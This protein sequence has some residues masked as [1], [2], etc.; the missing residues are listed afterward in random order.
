MGTPSNFP[1]DP[2]VNPTWVNIKAAAVPGHVGNTYAAI[3]DTLKFDS[4]VVIKPLEIPAQIGALWS[5]VVDDFMEVAWPA[6]V[7]ILVGTGAP[8]FIGLADTPGPSGTGPPDYKDFELFLLRVNAAGT[9]LEY[10]VTIP[11]TQVLDGT[12]DGDGTKRFF[13]ASD[14][15]DLIETREPAET[16]VLTWTAPGMTAISA[17][18]VRF[19]VPLTAVRIDRTGL[20]VTNRTDMSLASQTD[21][22][23]G[24][25]GTRAASFYTLDDTGAIKEYTSPPSAATLDAE[26]FLG[27]ALHDGSVI[28]S[29]FP[30][31]IVTGDLG[32]LIRDEIATTGNVKV[33][34]G[35][36]VD[37]KSTL[38]SILRSTDL[39]GPGL[40][41]V[42]DI[43]N[44]NILNIPEEDPVVFDVVFADGTVHLSDVSTLPKLFESTPGVASTYTGGKRTSISRYIL[45]PDG[46][47]YV[48]LGN[49]E[50]NNFSAAVDALTKDL[51]DN[52]LPPVARAIGV[53]LAVVI[54][55]RDQTDWTLDR[56]EI[57]VLGG[58]QVGGGGSSA[59]PALGDLTD[60]VI[61]A[62][63]EGEGIFYDGVADYVNKSIPNQ[64]V[65]QFEG[66]VAPATNVALP[67][68]IV[69]SK[70]VPSRVHLEVKTAPSTVALEVDVLSSGTTIFPGAVAKI[71]TSAFTGT[72][73][74][75][76]TALLANTPWTLNIDAGDATWQDL[77]VTIEGHIVP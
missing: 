35:G 54:I 51:L 41:F 17:T 4:N 9:G 20:T 30:A 26:A 71:V 38:F 74:P 53:L 29:A 64:Y 72:E 46:E 63:A 61:S 50:Y 52:P 66:N 49:V 12:T 67:L 5:N 58:G 28:S 69:A 43:V 25:P 65:F 44:Q 32:K 34:A 7:Q 14:I 73:T 8:T 59:T 27:V 6:I 23:V 36:V 15:T 22:I 37:E 77:T 57:I 11:H 39:F 10:A 47:V 75:N 76:T 68:H 60:V 33:S 18:T 2:L 3:L 1:F 19:F 48:Q 55:E 13:V 24:T 40:N 45:L 42:N 31:P 62:V 56:A 21:V 16:G 70:F